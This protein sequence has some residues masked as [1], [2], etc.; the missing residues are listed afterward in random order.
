M[1]EEQKE[2]FEV[3]VSKMHH[4]NANDTEK[5]AAQ[6]IAKRVTGLRLK[7]LTVL[8]SFGQDGAIGESIAEKADEWLYSVKPRLT[9]LAEIDFVEDSGKRQK[10]SRNRQEIVWSITQKGKKFLDD[11]LS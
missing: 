10:N 3:I 7:V 1:K 8:N 4:K 5:E 11:C 9:E 2:L 6:K